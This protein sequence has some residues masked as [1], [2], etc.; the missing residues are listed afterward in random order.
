MAPR[1]GIAM[2]I[3]QL[4]M[5]GQN[6]QFLL[7]ILLFLTLAL[8]FI[9]AAWTGIKIYFMRRSQHRAEEDFKRS[10]TGAD[11]RPLPPGGAGFCDKC[12]RAND[13]VYFLPDGTR[14]WEACYGQAQI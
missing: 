4:E 1:Q 6:I 14:R 11:G 7:G 9:I 5:W 8:A 12:G 10:R 13:K 2:L 3:A